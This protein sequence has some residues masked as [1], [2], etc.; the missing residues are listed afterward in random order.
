MRKRHSPFTTEEE[1]LYLSWNYGSGDTIEKRQHV[2]YWRRRTVIFHYSNGTNKCSVVGCN[3]SIDSLT[4]DHV[5]FDTAGLISSLGKKSGRSG[6]GLISLLFDSGLPDANVDVKCM[7]HNVANKHPNHSIN[8][9]KNHSRTRVRD[10]IPQDYIKK[11]SVCESAKNQSFFALS[12]STKDKLYPVC[13][14]CDNKRRKIQ[15]QETLIKAYALY[16]YNGPIEFM[17]WEH[18][19]NDGY[20]HRRYL[21]DKYKLKSRQISSYQFAAL[22]LREYESGIQNYPG[23]VVAHANDNHL[24]MK[25]HIK[26]RNIDNV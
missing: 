6:G 3:A 4:I 20:L 9:S 17:T 8:T 18:S 24:G 19:N 5:D 10:H 15:N 21:Q 23:L 1:R 25:N 22:L 7:A 14:E 26:E 11:C 16:G 13:R 12:N 2:R